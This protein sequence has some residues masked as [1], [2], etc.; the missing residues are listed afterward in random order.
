MRF[1]PEPLK[2]IVGDDLQRIV[3]ERGP[4]PRAEDRVFWNVRRILTAATRVNGRLVRV[5]RD[6]GFDLVRIDQ[7]AVAGL[8]DVGT[9]SDD[10]ILR[11]IDEHAVAARVLDVKSAVE[12][13]DDGVPARY[14]GIG[15][16]PIVVWKTT[17]RSPFYAKNLTSCR[18]KR[19]RLRPV[20][21]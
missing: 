21:F 7:D 13:P 6:H 14:V 12:E 20:D 2:R 10:S 8:D 19:A 18:A 11:R 1:Q 5:I 15:Q 9:P 16:H 4:I 3:R 17:D